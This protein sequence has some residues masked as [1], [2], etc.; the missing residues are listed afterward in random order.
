MQNPVR[1][2]QKFSMLHSRVAHG[3]GFALCLEPIDFQLLWTAC[4]IVFRMQ[5]WMGGLRLEWLACI[6]GCSTC[7]GS[8][9]QLDGAVGVGHIQKH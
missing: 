5:T 2:E 7:I 8:C 1:L 4:C 9:C 6:L 3:F